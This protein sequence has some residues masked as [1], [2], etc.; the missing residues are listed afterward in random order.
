M[1]SIKQNYIKIQKK[2]AVT[3]E[4][5]GIDPLNVEIVAVTKTH[6][7][8]IVIEAVESGIKHIGENKLQDAVEKLDQIYNIY[9]EF[10][11]TRHFIGHL[12][13]NKVKKAVS[14]FDI[15]E[16]VDSLK[17]AD[18]ISNTACALGKDVDIL[19]QVNTSGEESKFGI[20]PEKCSDLVKK[21]SELPNLNIRGL[22]TIGLF[23]DDMAK[24]RPCF[25]ILK[26]LFDEIDASGIPGVKMDYLSMGMS[27]DFEI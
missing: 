7:H 25:K 10:S 12:Q 4:K 18:A 5:S 23:S 8:D 3:A 17:L 20:V 21:V 9:P 15:I 6:S 2:I 26:H 11:V 16:S 19:I 13:T 24:V 14:Y 22:M 1:T 27:N